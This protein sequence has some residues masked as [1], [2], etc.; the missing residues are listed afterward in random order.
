M[1]ELSTFQS[2]VPNAQEEEED[3]NMN[4]FRDE[5]ANGLFNRSYKLCMI[6]FDMCV[7]MFGP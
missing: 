1:V 4:A 6:V 7:I 3:Q 5:I 2:N